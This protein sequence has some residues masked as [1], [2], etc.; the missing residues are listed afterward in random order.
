MGSRL[1]A[2]SKLFASVV[3][4]CDGYL[5]ALP[6]KPAWSIREELAKPRED[7]R[8]NLSAF[9]QPICTALQLGLVELWK[10]WGVRPQAVVGHSSGE[11][12]AAYAAGLLS[13]Q[14]AIIVA[15]YRGLHMG[16]SSSVLRSGPKGAMCAIGIAEEECQQILYSY[17]S[18]VA[19][20]AVNSPTS[21]TL[22]GDKDAIQEIVEHC[23]EKGIFCRA[24]QVDTGKLFSFPSSHN[25]VGIFAHGGSI[26]FPS[27]APSGAAVRKVAHQC[28]RMPFWRV[29][30]SQ[31]R[32]V[33]LCHRKQALFSQMHARIL[34]AEHGVHRPLQYRGHR[35]HASP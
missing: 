24:L 3:D 26:S 21:C 14:H 32:D 33:L 9:S 22:S 8:I 30:Q 35:S 5:A 27:Y 18:R 25:L 28:W 12:G 11:I 17:K 1:L 31:L 34:E 13:L 16:S 10:S 6:D 20:A 19:L 29:S 4:Q 2:T 7:S 23:K 15:Y